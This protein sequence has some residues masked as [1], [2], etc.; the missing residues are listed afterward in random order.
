M[1]TDLTGLIPHGWKG[2][3]AVTKWWRGKH[4]H[5]F[6]LRKAC[7]QCGDEMILDVT[8]AAIIG[9]A[10]NA[11]LHLTRCAKCRGQSK[12]DAPTSR[13]TVLEPSQPVQRFEVVDE[14][15][16]SARI[17][18]LEQELKEAYDGAA[19]IAQQAGGVRKAIHEQLNLSLLGDG[20]TY[21]TVTA[22]IRA[23]KGEHE[24]P[25]A[26]QQTAEKFDPHKALA[27]DIAKHGRRRALTPAER[28]AYEKT[29]PKG[30][31]QDGA[32]AAGFARTEPMP[33]ELKK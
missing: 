26:M 9:T 8:R 6:R 1:T 22:A 3:E 17:A 23:L 11:G 5:L 21:E 28:E 32:H 19:D 7:A 20:I 13:P 24:L 2:G 4:L 25:A 27:E 30:F 14:G 15:G 12:N 18:E 16:L 10:K 33:W 29:Q 31:P